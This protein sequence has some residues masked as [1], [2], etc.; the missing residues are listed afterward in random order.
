MAPHMPNAYSTTEAHPNSIAYVFC[1]T[2]ALI[3]LSVELLGHGVDICF[4]LVE[5]AE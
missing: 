2:Y 3:Y 4:T 5:I 1:Q